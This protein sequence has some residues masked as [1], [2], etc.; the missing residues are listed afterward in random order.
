MKSSGNVV[1]GTWNRYNFGGDP[2]Q[3]LDRGILSEDFLILH[4]DDIYW[5]YWALEEVLH[6]PSAIGIV[7]AYGNN[8][9]LLNS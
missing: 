1:N 3:H 5:T 6:S 4:S 2:E 8:R 9:T 7:I